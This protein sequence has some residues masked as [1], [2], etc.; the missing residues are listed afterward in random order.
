MIYAL[1]CDEKL[2][3]KP[4][5]EIARTSGIALGTVGQVIDNLKKLGFVIDMGGR[6]KNLI[7]G[8][9][10]FDRWC[11]DYLAGLLNTV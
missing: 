3:N 1:L 9:A 8:K 11:M 6:G 7:N 5:R 4:Y 2:L 10:L